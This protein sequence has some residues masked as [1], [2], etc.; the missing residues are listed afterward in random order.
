MQIFIKIFNKKQKKIRI[1]I[2]KIETE[3]NKTRN[4]KKKDIK[5]ILKNVKV[6]IFAKL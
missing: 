2:K 5:K 6:Q 1:K 4:D 3:W